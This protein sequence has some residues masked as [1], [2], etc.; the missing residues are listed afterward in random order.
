MNRQRTPLYMQICNI[1]AVVLMAGCIGALLYLAID[2]YR[3]QKQP[4]QS[5]PQTIEITL[6][7]DST[8]CMA[9]TDRVQLIDSLEHIMSHHERLLAER[10]Q[11]QLDKKAF[12]DN[13]ISIGSILLAIVVAIFGFFGFKNFQS[14]ETKAIDCAETQVKKTIRD[15]DFKADVEE[16]LQEK[17]LSQLGQIVSKKILDDVLFF[18]HNEIDSIQNIPNVLKQN[19]LAISDIHAMLNKLSAKWESKFNEIL[20]ETLPDNVAD[21]ENPSNPSE[22]NPF[23]DNEA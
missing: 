23:N 11:Y 4:P 10:Y 15:H 21:G 7:C 18:L 12:D 5:L 1:C 14:I 22:D 6:T 17:Y 9:E 3:C 19:S 13:L 8:V 16:T 2:I 20:W